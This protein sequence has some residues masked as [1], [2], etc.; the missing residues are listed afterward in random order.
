MPTVACLIRGVFH[1]RYGNRIIIFSSSVNSALLS[2]ALLL[3]LLDKIVPINTSVRNTLGLV[4][5]NYSL[6]AFCSHHDVHSAEEGRMG[7]CGE[8]RITDEP[9]E[10]TSKTLIRGTVTT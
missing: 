8:C 5:E 9:L 6:P 4:N 10:D 7:G 3:L 1:K 2:V